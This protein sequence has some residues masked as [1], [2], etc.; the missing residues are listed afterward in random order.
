MWLRTQQVIIPPD[1]LGSHSNPVVMTLENLY[2]GRANLCKK[3]QEL[4]N[5]LALLDNIYTAV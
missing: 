3:Q 4:A 5:M 1:A 2:V